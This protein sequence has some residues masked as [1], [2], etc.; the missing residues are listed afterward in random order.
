[1][2]SGTFTRPGQMIIVLDHWVYLGSA[3]GWGMVRTYATGSNSTLYEDWRR[4]PQ[5]EP[6]HVPAFG[7]SPRGWPFP[8][9]P[10]TDSEDEKPKTKGD[11]PMTEANAND[12]RTLDEG[13]HPGG[14]HHQQR[15]VNDYEGHE[16]DP[17]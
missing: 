14:G 12:N 3:K 13:D 5:V 7:P 10:M 15:R 2:V 9:T 4:V 8:I 17:P 16:G 1:M 6:P 11:Q